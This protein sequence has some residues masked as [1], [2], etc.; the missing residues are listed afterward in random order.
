MPVFHLTKGCE[1][2]YG[3]QDTCDQASLPA[4]F[5]RLTWTPD[6]SLF[7]GLSCGLHGCP[8]G[9]V[10]SRPL[11][12]SLLWPVTFLSSQFPQPTPLI[13]PPPPHRSNSIPILSASKE[14]KPVRT[15]EPK[16][17][18]TGTPG[19]PRGPSFPVSPGGPLGPGGPGGPGGPAWPW[20]PCSRE[21][22]RPTITASDK[23]P[24]LLFNT[25]NVY[26]L[27]PVYTIKRTRTTRNLKPEGN[28]PASRKQIN[29]HA[30]WAE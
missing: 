9:W 30:G 5:L 24:G 8:V 14:T 19:I 29:I 25:L 13:W 12:A 27:I 28:L 18:L 21:G 10:E 2:L 6:Q 1:V 17:R 22:D 23:D 3:T 26:Y 16:K 15:T 20:S 11:W 7:P 4:G